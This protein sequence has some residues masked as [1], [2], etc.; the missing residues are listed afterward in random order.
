MTAP[1]E[2]PPHSPRPRPSVLA[3]VLH[4]PAWRVGLGLL[5]LASAMVYVMALEFDAL[6]SQV[7]AAFAT[8]GSVMI[9]L[10]RFEG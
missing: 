8:G 2:R 6:M 7:F 4:L 1:H 9:S 10:G 5:G 3:R